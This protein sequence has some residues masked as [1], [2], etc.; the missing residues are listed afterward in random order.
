MKTTLYRV[1][2]TWLG[3]DAPTE[4][5]FET[6]AAAESNLRHLGNGEVEKVEITSDYP[7]NYRSGAT[8]ADL[9]YG[10]FDVTVK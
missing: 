5:Y 1:R 9:T 10:N 7:L 3:A 2:T 6:K 4:Y 8:L